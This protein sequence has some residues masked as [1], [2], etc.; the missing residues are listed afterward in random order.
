VKRLLAL[1]VIAAAVTTGC[2]GSFEEAKVTGRIQRV[3]LGA[4]PQ[5]APIPSS[6]CVSLDDGRRLW[7][8]IAKGAA[9]A[10]GAGGIATIPIE[11]KTGRVI[12]ASGALVVAVVAGVAVY[13]SEDYGTTW[14]RECSAP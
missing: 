5:A 14:A 2:A 10:A 11:D 1:A 9:I 4:P 6:R 7:G 13:V 12:I 3:T 8:G